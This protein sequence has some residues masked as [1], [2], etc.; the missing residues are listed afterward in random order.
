MPR[1][2]WW[3]YRKKVGWE[4]IWRVG[5]TS[6]RGAR[7]TRSLGN[8]EVAPSLTECRGAAAFVS[9]ERREGLPHQRCH[10]YD[11]PNKLCG[12]R[13]LWTPLTCFREGRAL[14]QHS[15]AGA[16][17]RS[18]ATRP[19][20]SVHSAVKHIHFYAKTVSLILAGA[21]HTLYNGDVH[22]MW[23]PRCT[24]TQDGIRARYRKV[25]VIRRSSRPKP[26]GTTQQTPHLDHDIDEMSLDVGAIC[27][28]RRLLIAQVS[29]GSSRGL[30]E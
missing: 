5:F 27:C 22:S 15:A 19:A 20:S 4:R 18:K 17:R 12:A 10:L 8:S 23:Q 24:R 3:C 2:R 9:I 7:H 1:E 16:V 29:S 30:M 14:P 26:S 25:A 13:D 21:L 11:C 28:A 6:G